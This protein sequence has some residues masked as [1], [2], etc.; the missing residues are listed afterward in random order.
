MAKVITWLS[1]KKTYLLGAAVVGWGLYKHFF[2]D[3][4]S[5][6]AT[7]EWIFSGTGIMTVRAAL[8]KIGLEA[9]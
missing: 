5:W 9:K 7:I 8:A 1:G 2:G 3:H 6:D 4:L